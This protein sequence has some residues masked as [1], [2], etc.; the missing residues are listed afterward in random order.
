[1]H[2][3]GRA[4]VQH[5]LQVPLQADL[6][7]VR[8]GALEQVGRKRQRERLQ[9]RPRRRS[10]RVAPRTPDR[11]RD[12][13]IQDVRLEGSP[14]GQAADPGVDGDLP[15]HVRQNRLPRELRERRKVA[16]TLRRRER[17]RRR[18]D[19]RAPGRPEDAQARGSLQ[20]GVG[21]GVLRVVEAQFLQQRDVDRVR[22]GMEELR[23]EIDGDPPPPVL[24][25]PRIAVAADPG[26]RLEEV[27][28]EATGKKVGRGHAARTGADDRHAF[29]PRPRS[30]ASGGAGRQGTERRQA[31]RALD[32]IAAS[33]RRLGHRNHER[34]FHGGEPRSTRAESPVNRP[35][36][37]I[38]RCRCR[39]GCW[40]EHRRALS[41]RTPTSRCRSAT[42][43]RR[44]RAR[45]SPPGA[46]RAA[47]GTRVALR[48][49]PLLPARQHVRP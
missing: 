37:A 5:A 46:G 39:C 48:S 45:E 9:D 2:L 23:A 20:R 27:D 44:V 35:R 1:M 24:D 25:H 31:D 15:R 12:P 26:S 32:G 30:S 43:G 38:R 3:G 14:Q 13:R 22:V 34:P 7:V 8:G 19:G 33:Q 29:T 41:S 49:R 16:R 47:T 40:S 28:V 21:V 10:P 36:T 11:R 42:A 18:E 6:R 17:V 4:A